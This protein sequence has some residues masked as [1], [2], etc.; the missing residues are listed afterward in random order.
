MVTL[1]RRVRGGLFWRLVHS[2]WWLIWHLAKCRNRSCSS[3]LV[4]GRRPRFGTLRPRCSRAVRFWVW[5]ALRN[6]SRTWFPESSTVQAAPNPWLRVR[7]NTC[8]VTGNHPRCILRLHWAFFQY[9]VFWPRCLLFVLLVWVGSCPWLNLRFPS[10]PR[11]RSM[12]SCG[13]SLRTR[14]LRLS[15]GTR[16]TCSGC[17]T[18]CCCSKR[19][20]GYLML[21]G[22]S[23][24]LLS[25]NISMPSTHLD[26]K[27]TSLSPHHKARS[28][29]STPCQLVTP[30]AQACMIIPIFECTR[31][32]SHKGLFHSKI[33]NDTW[34]QGSSFSLLAR[35][36]L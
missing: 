14:R 6:R 3:R 12:P 7:D 16:G 23:F 34:L 20:L 36:K 4:S 22:N 9:K 30:N 19:L 35:K 5:K 2:T 25:S 11:Y 8:G 18:S 27:S 31:S 33:L 28:R 21:E 24:M 10:C 17:C 15:I 13:D 26:S 32:A 1:S 29:T